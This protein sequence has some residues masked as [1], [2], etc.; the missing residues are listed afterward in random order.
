MVKDLDIKLAQ[1]SKIE[2]SIILKIFPK[3]KKKLIKINNGDHSLSKKNDL[4]KICRE[5][6]YITQ[7][8]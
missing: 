2:T 3:A 5:L 4:K 6:D 8:L 7:L 1:F